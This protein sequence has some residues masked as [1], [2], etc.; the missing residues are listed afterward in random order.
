VAWRADP[1]WGALYDQVAGIAADFAQQ[2][3]ERQRRRELDPADFERLRQAGLPLIGVP[4]ELGGLWVDRQRSVRPICELLRRLA[5]GDSSVALVSA[6][7]IPVLSAWLNIPEAPAAFREAWQAQR[8]QVFQTVLDGAFWGTIVSEPGSGGDSG[9]SRAVARPTGEPGRYLLS[10]QK[11][12]GSGSGISTFMTTTAIPEGEQEPASFF[13]NLRDVPWDGSQGVRLLAAWD[14]HGMTATQSHA[15]LFERFP[16]TRSAWQ[17]S[18]SET[19][20]ITGGIGTCL[21]TAVIVGVVDTAFEAARQLLRP[22]ARSLRAYER[23]EWTR[24]AQDEWLIHQAYAG[25]LRTIERPTA[26]N[27]GL[28]RGKT[29]IAELAETSLGRLCRVLGGSSFSRRSPFGFWFEDV[30]A[31]GFLRPP[32]GLAFDRLFETSSILE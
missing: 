18:R 26:S 2:R 13:L 9:A 5:S 1:R 32:W 7:H 24:A 27:T 17:G 31:L 12:F 4:A 29:A 25:M 3:A 21:F 11:H 20:A 30:R 10:G 16:V 22:K 19:Q 23:V 8:L 14:G 28:L 6:M 15:M